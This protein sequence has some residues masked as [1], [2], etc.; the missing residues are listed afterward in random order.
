MGNGVEALARICFGRLNAAFSQALKTG[1][2][3]SPAANQ[4]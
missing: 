2:R 3:T 4:A 1:R